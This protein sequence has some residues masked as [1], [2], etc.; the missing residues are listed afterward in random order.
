MHNLA[1]G[2]MNEKNSIDIEKTIG[3]VKQCDVQKD[4]LG[5]RTVLRACIEMDLHK[6][7]TRGQTIKIQ[8]SYY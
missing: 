4:S 3:S 5:W 7:V 6:P 8:S 2:Y 1:I